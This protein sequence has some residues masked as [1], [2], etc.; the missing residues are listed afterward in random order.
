LV[1]LIATVA[2]TDVLARGVGTVV[3]A[4]TVGLV[5]VG[6]VVGDADLELL[7]HC[8]NTDKRRAAHE[9]SPMSC[10][11]RGTGVPVPARRHASH[12]RHHR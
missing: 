5:V 4:T 1:D 11:L 12:D 7:E 2:L 10:L 9:R 8:A 3:D 6:E